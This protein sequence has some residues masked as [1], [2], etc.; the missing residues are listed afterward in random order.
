M[1]FQDFPGCQTQ[2]H[3]DSNSTDGNTDG[4][5]DNKDFDDRDQHDDALSHTIEN[6]RSDKGGDAEENEEGDKENEE[7]DQENGE[8]DEGDEEHSQGGYGA[9]K[10]MS[11]PTSVF[12]G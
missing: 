8:G 2:E 7:S 3:A 4:D 10:N 5:S 9:D 6:E 1:S 12:Y 11:N